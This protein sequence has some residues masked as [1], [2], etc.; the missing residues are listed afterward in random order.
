ME[1]ADADAADLGK[2]CLVTVAY[3]K[4]PPP[5]PAA[6]YNFTHRRLRDTKTVT[7][8]HDARRCTARHEWCSEP[9]RTGKRY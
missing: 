6:S 2:L 3:R 7:A 1:K 8:Q 4:M 9:E 5:P